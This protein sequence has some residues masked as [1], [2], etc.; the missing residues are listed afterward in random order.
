MDERQKGGSWNSVKLD[1]GWTV[2]G[3]VIGSRPLNMQMHRKGGSPL[4]TVTGASGGQRDQYFNLHLKLLKGLTAATLFLPFTSDGPATKRMPRRIRDFYYSVW[5]FPPHPLRFEIMRYSVA[6]FE[7]IKKISN[8]L[9]IIL[10]EIN[11][12]KFAINKRKWEGRND[13]T[14]PWFY[15][16]SNAVH[17]RDKKRKSVQFWNSV[18]ENLKKEKKL[19]MHRN[20]QL[21][22]FKQTN[23]HRSYL[24][25]F[26]LLLPF[27]QILRGNYANFH[28]HAQQ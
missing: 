5:F 25:Q 11:S 12:N 19:S 1:G 17:N 7:I 10:N 13:I 22:S 2:C 6:I 8:K 23:T 21:R 4:F 3:G 16:L 20:S 28:K 14:L 27:R 26:F 9:N 24:R 15:S 18:K